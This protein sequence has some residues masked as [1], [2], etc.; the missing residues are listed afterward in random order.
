MNP[1]SAPTLGSHPWAASLLAV[2][3]DERSATA[4]ILALALSAALGF[5]YRVYRLS[6]GGPLEDAIGGAVLATMLVAIGVLV[7]AGAGWARWAAL[8]YAVLFGVIVMPIWILGVYIPAR[9]GPLDHAV[10]GAYWLSLV[11]VGVAALVY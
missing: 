6:K 8:V 1:A 2:S 7:G 3:H 4:L 9:P 11:A 10:V 5:G